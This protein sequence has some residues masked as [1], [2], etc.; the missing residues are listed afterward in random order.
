M[1]SHVYVDF[2]RLI[3]RGERIILDKQNEQVS[4]GKEGTENI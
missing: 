1:N 4:I 2:G 3:E